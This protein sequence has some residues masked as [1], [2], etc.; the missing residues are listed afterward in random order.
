MDDELRST[1]LID[2]DRLGRWIDSL[3]LI[4]G[5]A[6]LAEPSDHRATI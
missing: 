4:K 2:P 3:D 6:E 5:A 1:S